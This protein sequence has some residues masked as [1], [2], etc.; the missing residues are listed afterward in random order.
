MRVRE[1]TAYDQTRVDSLYRQAAP[2]I[3]MFP[4]SSALVCA[5]LIGFTEMP[6]LPLLVWWGGIFGLSLVRWWLTE[7]QKKS[8]GEAL[9]YER[10]YMVL[11]LIC[12]GFAGAIC[13]LTLQLS[14]LQQLIPLLVVV[15]EVVSA[16]VVMVTCWRVFAAFASMAVIPFSLVWLFVGTQDHQIAALLLLLPFSFLVANTYRHFYR[17]A[18]E[19]NKLRFEREELVAELA[20]NNRELA[21]ARD[22]A[23]LNS[24]AKSE[25]LNTLGAQLKAPLMGQLACLNLLHDRSK[26]RA[27]QSLVTASQHNAAQL[28]QLV[29]DLTQ[30]E[31]LDQD[32]FSLKPMVFNLRGV[33]EEVMELMAPSAH[34]KKVQLEAAID[35]STPELVKA[36][37]GKFRRLLLNMLTPAIESTH[38]GEILLKMTFSNQQAFLVLTDTGEGRTSIP[39]DQTELL[40][41]LPLATRLTQVMGGKLSCNASLAKG[42]RV[43]VSV[44]MDVVSEPVSVPLVDTNQTVLV[45]SPHGCVR[46]SVEA[47]L[48]CLGYQAHLVDKLDIAEALLKQSRTSA[49]L[50]ADIDAAKPDK[51][52]WLAERAHKQGHRLLLLRRF[53]QTAVNSPKAAELALPTSVSRIENALTVTVRDKQAE[54]ETE[55]LAAQRQK[56][57]QQK[58]PIAAGEAL[59]HQLPPMEV[60]VLENLFA[61]LGWR[62]KNVDVNSLSSLPQSSAL[63]QIVV[64]DVSSSPIADVVMNRPVIRVGQAG[65]ER[66]QLTR[67]IDSAQLLAELEKQL[68]TG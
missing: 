47:Q 60:L 30:L 4:F 39:D 59:L 46:L 22:Q 66:A 34:L 8:R 10:A 5:Y 45:V 31:A 13:V 27:N 29:D 44:P 11:E 50:I 61:E 51:W 33:V 36:D 2:L 48:A 19:T 68:K 17:F 62:T 37:M 35:Q 32:A 6:A 67:P 21:A 58:Q 9:H 40:P 64:A 16:V 63:P 52:S 55:V 1:Q 53:N 14:F 57:K 25:L 20:D 18:D 49:I 3:L 54:P 7:K 23:E 65:D 24:L 28:L 26:G 12:G 41:G 38:K 42:T 43:S 15:G 56:Q